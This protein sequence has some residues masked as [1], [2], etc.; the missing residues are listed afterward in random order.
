MVLFTHAVPLCFLWEVS[1]LVRKAGTLSKLLAVGRSQEDSSSESSLACM[2]STLCFH[3]QFEKVGRLSRQP[4]DSLGLENTG[5][6]DCFPPG[7]FLKILNPRTLCLLSTLYNSLLWFLALFNRP[8][9]IPNRLDQGTMDLHHFFSAWA[10]INSLSVSLIFINLSLYS[11]KFYFLW[12]TWLIL[13][14]PINRA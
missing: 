2:M 10:R 4:S 7:V 13:F 9:A 11:F 1:R 12:N 5:L 6:N 8:F 14:F 3:I